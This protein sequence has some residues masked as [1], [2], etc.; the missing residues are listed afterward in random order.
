[1]H[2]YVHVPFCA[3][4]CVYC[5]FAIAVRRETPNEE[6]VAAIG[7][8]WETWK[9]HPAWVRSPVI[10]TIYFGGGTPSRLAPEAI[11]RLI[12]LFR[13]G[14]PIAEGTEVTLE[15]NPDDITTERAQSWRQAGVNRVSLGV[16]SFDPAVLEWMHRT[17]RAEQIPE[18]MGA[19][20][21]A[22]H[23]NVSV[24]LIY[25][26]PD[27]MRRDWAA[28]LDQAFALAPTHLSLY[29][30][31]V[32]AHT[33]LGR[34]VE[35]GQAAL[36]PSDRAAAEYLVAHGQLR[37][38]GFEHYEVSNAALP[39]HWSR[40]N[41]AY[42]LRSP[43]IGLGPSAHTGLWEERAWNVRDWVDYERRTRAGDVVL[44]GRERLTAEQVRLEEL[45]LG[46]RTSIGLPVAALGDA[47]WA[48][49]VQSGW[50]V[51]G[52]GTLRLTA[53]GWLRLDALVASVSHF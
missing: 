33:P 38:R 44:A 37:A 17:H 34:W 45:Y 41:L 39:G 35:R 32:E 18:A 51:E 31:T 27:T 23:H 8:E 3:R 1:M 50:A 49:W 52:N 24:D 14:H 28:D 46:L 19:L 40:H 10:D 29:G 25:G 2:L 12:D 42:W 53:E 43:F 20:R 7:R 11:A 15:A 9:Q 36:P 13:S 48:V 5:D 6:F 21:S 26:L 22:G 30:L 47:A 4:R 16:Q